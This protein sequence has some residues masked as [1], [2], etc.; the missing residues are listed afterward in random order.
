MSLEVLLT[1]TIYQFENKQVHVDL[2]FLTPALPEDVLLLSRPVTYVTCAVTSLDGKEH[3][4]SFHFDA[5]G[6][7]TTDKLDQPVVGEKVDFDTVSALKI[8]SKSQQVLVRS[9]DDLRI[10][11]GYLYVA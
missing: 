2:T 10:D 4:V 11:W 9:G 6:E 3:E 5:G 1:K 7:L 8:G